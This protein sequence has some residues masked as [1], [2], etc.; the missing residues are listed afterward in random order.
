MEI[1][2]L[3][4]TV[5]GRNALG[6]SISEITPKQRK[7]FD[8]MYDLSFE[9]DFSLITISLKD[10]LPS[11][12]HKFGLFSIPIKREVLIQSFPSF[13]EK[14]KLNI[15]KSMSEKGCGKDDYLLEVL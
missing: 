15:N 2:I 12:I 4:L 14:F 1:R 5:K 3:G 10:P 7:F 8:L 6:E 11:R 13:S 9:K